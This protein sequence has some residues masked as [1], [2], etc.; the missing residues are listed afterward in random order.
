[1]VSAFLQDFVDA[2]VQQVP[3]LYGEVVAG[4]RSSRRGRGMVGALSLNDRIGLEK[5]LGLT[6]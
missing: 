5:F 3:L 1:V 6:G 2:L 4:G